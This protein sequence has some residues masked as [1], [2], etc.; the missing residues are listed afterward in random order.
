[1]SVLSSTFTLKTKSFTFTVQVLLKW[2]TQSHRVSICPVR[3]GCASFC[4]YLDVCLRSEWPLM[5]GQTSLW[6]CTGQMDGRGDSATDTE[7]WGSSVAAATWPPS[8]S[9][10][11]LPVPART[12]TMMQQ[13]TDRHN[14][15]QTSSWLYLYIQIN[16]FG[17][18]ANAKKLTRAPR[19]RGRN[20]NCAVER[21]KPHGDDK[22]ISPQKRKEGEKNKFTSRD[23]GEFVTERK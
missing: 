6:G 4:L 9:S 10:R 12:L 17:L 2:L 20:T 16:I 1:M 11:P 14:D 21:K 23:T 13:R 3:R 19:Q 7:D 15:F 5:G 22:N 18:F 8:L